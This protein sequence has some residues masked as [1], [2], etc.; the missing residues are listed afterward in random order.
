MTGPEETDTLIARVAMGDQDAFQ[1][2]YAGTSEFLFGLCL[3][4]LEDDTEAE[5]IL[6]DVYTS[7]WDDADGFR[8]QSVSPNRL[9][10]LTARSA[11]IAQKR[12]RLSAPEEIRTAD[13]F[14]HPENDASADVVH[15]TG[16]LTESMDALPP[17]RGLLLRRVV[18][19]G[20]GYDDLAVAA[21]VDAT[22]VRHSMQSTLLR[23]SRQLDEATDSTDAAAIAAAETA[24][25]LSDADAEAD[26]ELKDIW[27]REIAQVIL[28]NTQPVAPP[29]QVAR[30]LFVR[31]FGEKRETIW[32]QLWPYAVGGVVAA[33]MLWIAV[34]NDLLLSLE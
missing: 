17:A 5:E 18:H 24:L 6:Q 19:K 29:K 13:L 21:D 7:V 25:G 10:I 28:E 12:V 34:S 3:H 4:V 30:R 11:A 31:V 20:E 15:G 14:R 26:P 23:V 1:T 8:G 16:S 33:L 27:R 22:T 9:L 2:L 32:E